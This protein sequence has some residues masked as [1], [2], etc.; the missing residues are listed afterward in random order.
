MDAFVQFFVE[1]GYWGMFLSAVIAG[2]VIPLSSEAVLV[3]CVGPLHLDPWLC[4]ISATA[5]NVAGGMTCY[6]M[7]TLGNMKW[8]ERY[9]HVSHE[10]LERAQ[11]FIGG[12]GAWVA[13]FA[14]IP[15]LGSALTVALGLMRANIPITILAMTI[16]KVLRYALVIAGTLGVAAII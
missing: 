16:G 6:W 12:R 10:K 14:F 15:V 9:A 11:R 3:A 2:S 13:F 4:L 5:G 8:I 1:W 7:G